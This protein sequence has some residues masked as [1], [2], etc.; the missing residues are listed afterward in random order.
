VADDDR[1][2]ALAPE[3]LE[4]LFVER[5]N[6]GDVD[7]LV[8]LFEPDAVLASPPATVASGSEAIRRVLHDL[9]ASG[10]RLTLGDQ[11][12]TLRVGDVALTSTRLRDGGVTA[13]VARRQPDGTWRW[14]IDQWNVLGERPTGP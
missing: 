4:R 12:P 8:A 1:P 2:R 10:V 5:V 13:E 6:A 3:D 7:G 9:V 14:V 11:Q